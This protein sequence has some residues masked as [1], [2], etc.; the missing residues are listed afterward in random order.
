MIYAAATLAMHDD[1]Q[2]R[3]IEEIDAV[4]DEAAREGRQEL[5]YD[6]DYI[7]FPYTLAFMVGHCCYSSLLLLPSSTNLL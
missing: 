4:F 3:M 2:D 5:N 1:L 7:K 6:Q